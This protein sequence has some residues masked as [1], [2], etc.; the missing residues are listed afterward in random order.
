MGFS[1]AGAMGA[2]FAARFEQNVVCVIG[3]GGFNMNIQELQTFKNYGIKVKVF[4]LN[5]HIYGITKAFQETNFQG[6]CE[7]CGP[8]GYIPPDFM[9]ISEAY[10]VKTVVINNNEELNSKISEVLDTD[11][12]AICDVNCHEWHTYEPRIFGWRTPIED[13]FP[14][15]PRNEFKENMIGVSPY[16]NWKDPELPGK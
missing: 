3:D 8:K 9:K 2:W 14:Y 12:L 1:F 16:E 11:E 4:I 7:A 13:M 15:L 6:R 5:N 10:G